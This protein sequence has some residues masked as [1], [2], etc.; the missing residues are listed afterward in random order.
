VT[1]AESAPTTTAPKA[2]TD[3]REAVR[4]VAVLQ[5]VNSILGWDQETMM[6]EGGLDWRATQ[7]ATLA[8]MAHAAFTGAEMG[9]RISAA[10]EAVAALPEEHADRVDVREL[11]R[12]WDKATRLPESLVRELAELSSKAMHEWAAAR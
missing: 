2:I 12:D 8:S 10:E 5:S 11:R 6:P 4:K 7:Q 9:D 3:L 1:L